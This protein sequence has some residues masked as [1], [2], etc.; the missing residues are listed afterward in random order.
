[1]YVK[2]KNDFNQ[3]Y[4]KNFQEDVKIVNTPT[5][6]RID[7]KSIISFSTYYNHSVWITKE[8]VA[9]GIGD[10]REFQFDP[11]SKKSIY[12]TPRK[13][14]FLNEMF[15][16]SIFIS[17]VCGESYT[18]YLTE[19]NNE[20]EYR[21][22]IHFVDK[23]FPDNQTTF[24]LKKNA[25]IY[26]GNYY[27]A[28]IT[29]DNVLY[30][31]NVDTYKL[32][33]PLNDKVQDIALCANFALVLTYNYDVI[34][35]PIGNDEAK[36]MKFKILKK[37]NI[38][39]LSGTFDH[40]V[41][42][43]SEKD[44]PYNYHIFVFRYNSTKQQPN[45]IN[46]SL[47]DFC[48]R[49]IYFKFVS[50]ADDYTLLLTY[51]GVVYL[52]K[53]YE[54]YKEIKN[55]PPVKFI[56][57]GRDSQT[58]LASEV[59]DHM[60]NY[61]VSE[62]INDEEEE[63]ESNE[64]KSMEDDLIERKIEKQI[65]LTLKELESLSQE[66]FTFQPPKIAKKTY[67]K[68]STIG[69]PTY[70]SETIKVQI[71]Q[72]DNEKY[73][74]LKLLKSIHITDYCNLINKI[75]KI[76]ADAMHPL[77]VKPTA[78]NYTIEKLEKERNQKLEQIRVI[79]QKE[80][81]NDRKINLNNNDEEEDQN[82]T[83]DSFHNIDLKVKNDIERYRNDFYFPF[84]AMPYFPQNLFDAIEDNYFNNTEKIFIITEI[85]VAINYLHESGIYHQ[86][87][88]PWNILISNSK[89][90][91]ISD[92][93]N[94]EFIENEQ[95]IILKDE[96][97][98]WF[99]D[100]EIINSDILDYEQNLDILKKN[101]DIYSIGK[102]ILFIL[103]GLIGETNEKTFGERLYEQILAEKNQEDSS[104]KDDSTTELPD[105]TKKLINSCL[106][107]SKEGRPSAQTILEYIK[108]IN[109]KL[110]P[111]VNEKIIEERLSVFS[112]Q[113]EKIDGDGANE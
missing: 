41:A 23:N 31:V 44:N 12:T 27:P 33:K 46:I 100:P 85:V 51:K 24:K 4:T 10:N 86:R 79:E 104:N 5:K 94:S 103:T 106:S 19:S 25:Y 113:P 36:K 1:M 71:N 43:A 88:T 34:S 93:F 105:E 13:V 99:I 6:N 62:S 110:I 80:N 65:S 58:F 9:F 35:I 11:C 32:D 69:Y 92:V 107:F 83:I 37:Y 101:H 112:K 7:P 78:Y 56:I 111:G 89:D 15:E 72:K 66:K 54:D 28:I 82:F 17:A 39:T 109:Y 70:H 63:E 108:S 97:S 2:G 76:H 75:E 84:I 68:I 3:L 16:G 81:N 73:Y 74:A 14:K 55:I 53:D 29:D 90:A 48:S 95:T 8:N 64:F 102:L 49:K 50:C 87:L 20:T 47:S 30:I 22:I 98:L 21:S 40:A 91:F 96:K 26:G 52:T 77:I 59:S 38:Q 67:K 18:L 57:A 45:I 61:H 42:I 60:A